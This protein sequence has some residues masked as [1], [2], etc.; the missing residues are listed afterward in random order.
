MSDNRLRGLARIVDPSRGQTV[1]GAVVRPYRGFCVAV[2]DGRVLVGLWG[3]AG[4]GW[5]GACEDCGF[6]VGGA[7]SELCVFFD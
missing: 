6:V 5:E 3:G 2:V 1:V 7:V 4:E